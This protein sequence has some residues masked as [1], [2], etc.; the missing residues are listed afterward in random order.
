MCAL[1]QMRIYA[2][3]LVNSAHLTSHKQG[4]NFRFRNRKWRP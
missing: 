3:I 4:A 1:I 2:R